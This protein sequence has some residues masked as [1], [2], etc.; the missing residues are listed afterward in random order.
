MAFRDVWTVD[1]V[2]TAR[3][4]YAEVLLDD[5]L[6]ASAQLAFYFLLGFFP[7]VAFLAAAAT[8]FANL[9]PGELEHVALRALS[10]VMPQQALDLVE[11]NVTQVIRTLTAKNLRLMILSATLAL[12]PASGGMRAIIVTLNRAYNVREGRGP[13]RVYAVSITITLALCLTLLVAVP[14]FSFASSIR[15]QILEASG[16]AWA[17]AFH[18]GSRF[19]TIAALVFGIEFIYHV[20]PNA[21]RPWHWITPGSIVAVMVWLVATWMFGRYVSRFGRY[22]ALYA[23]LGSPVVLLLWFYLTGLAILIGGEIN[24]EVERQS[25]L[26]PRAAVPAP[27]SFDAAG[28]DTSLRPPGRDKTTADRTADPVEA[29]RARGSPGPAV[30]PRRQVPGRSMLQRRPD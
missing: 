30:A 19:V 23:G 18:L 20:A 22:E 11:R 29:A 28:H 3:R 1:W 24:A 14:M 2:A 15:D 27:P 25:G 10:D 5:C 21:R 8:T 7:F 12:W 9:P 4:V 13:W 17:T 26:M 16:P 6:G